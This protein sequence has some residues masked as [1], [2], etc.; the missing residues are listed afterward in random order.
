M[1]NI[2]ILGGGFAGLWSALV[3]RRQAVDEGRDLTITLVSMDSQLTLRPRLYEPEP[4]RFRIP[5]LPVLDPV[6]ID[7]IEGTVTTLDLE[8]RQVVLG[9]DSRALGYDRLILAT[10]SVLSPLSVPGAEGAFDLDNWTAAMAFDRH[11]KSAMP[12]LDKPV[13]AIIGAGFTGIE[14]AMEMR[15]RIEIAS[16]RSTADAARVILLDRADVPG[17]ALGDNPRPIIETALASAAIELRLGVHVAA[18]DATGLTLADGER[19]PADIVVACGGMVASPLTEQVGSTRDDQG[20]LFVR[21]DLRVDGFPDVFATGDVAH[22]KVDD[23]GHVALMSCQHAMMM[24]RFAGYN[25]T[26]DFLGLATLPYRQ[27]RYV[28]C[29]DLG[30]AGAVFTSG[31]N[32]EVEKSGAEAKKIKETINGEIIYPPTGGRDQILAAATLVPGHHKSPP[33][34]R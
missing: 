4:E 19:V 9:T 26:R 6:D 17:S 31:W 11:L 18:I 28:T 10:G 21:P 2:L 33:E 23:A 27:E 32:R 29:L 13:I 3:A 24:G 22:A 1:S 12:G 16:D 25:A 15:N 7:L 14:A 30:S 34:N 5:L 8:N 20:R